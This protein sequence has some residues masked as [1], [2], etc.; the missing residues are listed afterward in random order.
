MFLYRP[1]PPDVLDRCKGEAL[2]FHTCYHHLFVLPV[3]CDRIGIFRDANDW[4]EARWNKAARQYGT[5]KMPHVESWV[6]DPLVFC[7]YFQLDDHAF[8]F[9]MRWC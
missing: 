2:L 8:E 9:R 7:V 4:C 5:V 1:L 6:C 3:L